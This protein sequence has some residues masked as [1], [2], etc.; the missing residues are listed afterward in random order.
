MDRLILTNEDASRSEIAALLVLLHSGFKGFIEYNRSTP[1]ATGLEE[2][3]ELEAFI[4]NNGPSLLDQYAPRLVDFMPPA[5]ILHYVVV[6][7]LLFNATIV[8]HNF[9]LWRIDARHLKLE[10]RAL[11]LFGEQLTIGEIERLEPEPGQFSA[12]DIA[13]LD[14]IIQQ[15]QELRRWARKLSLSLVAPMGS[16]MLYRNQENLIYQQLLVLRRF[17]ERLDG[18][19]ND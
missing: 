8:W 15:A 11:R 17:R 2:S 10:E 9:R 18:I 16:E 12:E 19:G 3:P 13:L 4:Q 6:V 14:D 7:S 5:N 1:N